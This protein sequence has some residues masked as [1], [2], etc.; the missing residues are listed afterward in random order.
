MLTFT[1]PSCHASVDLAAIASESPRSG[2]DL[3]TASERLSGPPP[4]RRK[5]GRKPKPKPPA[6]QSLANA[7]VHNWL[8][9]GRPAFGTVDGGSIL[10]WGERIPASDVLPTYLDWAF[11]NG[12]R[13][14]TARPLY[15]ALTRFGVYA[16]RSGKARFHVFPEAPD[17]GSP[18]PC[19]R[20][21][22]VGEWPF[23]PERL[24]WVGG[25]IEASAY[26]P[27]GPWEDYLRISKGSGWVNVERLA[28]IADTPSAAPS[29]WPAAGPEEWLDAPVAPVAPAAAAGPAGGA[30]DAGGVDAARGPSLAVS[31]LV[32]GGWPGRSVFAPERRATVVPPQVWP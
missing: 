26:D 6:P 22:P 25:W 19:P 5:P 14:I 28:Y 29:W 23:P 18:P 3:V 20:I 8:V 30:F 24:P 7:A 17:L 32:D 2:Q 9:Y 21:Q 15:Q 4:A 10:P 12:V 1:C 27:A 13:L 31:G 16:E 11:H